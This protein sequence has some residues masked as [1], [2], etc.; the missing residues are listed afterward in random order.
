MRCCKYVSFRAIS[1][2]YVLNI[3]QK[4]KKL[5]QIKPVPIDLIVYSYYNRAM[6]SKAIIR[7]NVRG[8][9]LNE[10]HDYIKCTEDLCQM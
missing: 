5:Q 9:F 4:P 3:S 1:I 2:L 7:S 8:R 10:E 6:N